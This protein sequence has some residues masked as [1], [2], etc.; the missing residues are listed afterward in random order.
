MLHREV[1]LCHF[2]TSEFQCIQWMTWSPPPDLT[3]K[4]FHW[5]GETQ[6]SAAACRLWMQ[7]KWR[8]HVPELLTASCRS[9]GLPCTIYCWCKGREQC[10][11]NDNWKQGDNGGWTCLTMV[12]EHGHYGGW[13]WRVIMEDW[14]CLTM[15]DE[16]E[17][18]LW[19]VTM[20]DEHEGSL[21]RVTMEDEHEWSLWRVTME[22]DYGGWLWRVTMEDDYRGWTCLTMEDEHEWSL[23]GGDYGGWPWMRNM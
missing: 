11:L 9:D 13:L 18:W 22:G 10:V 23:W 16:H 6:S 3:T 17:G 5:F 19:R 8:H 15:E 1:I 7:D 20:E 2:H 4:C 14:I 12:D 21:W